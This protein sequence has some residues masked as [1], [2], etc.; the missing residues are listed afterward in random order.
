MSGKP[1]R[2]WTDLDLDRN[3]KATGYFRVPYSNDM[4]GYGSIPLPLCVVGNGDGPRV[5]LM[6]GNH[7]DEYE[8][9]VMLVKLLRALAPEN[10]QGR[11]IILPAAN[12]PAAYAGR[13]VSPIDG[14]NLNRLFPGDADG[15]PTAMIAHFIESTLLPRVDYVFDFH[16]GGVSTEYLPLAHVVLPEHEG[17]RAKALEFLRVFAM[18]VSVVVTGLLGG[19]QRL[20]GACE[21]RGISHM[22]TELG[23]AGTVSL[24]ALRAAE[25]GLRRLLH[26]VGVL[27]EPPA[28]NVPPPTRRMVRQP[29]RD[30]LYAPVDGIFEPYV[31]LGETV[32]V[33]QPAGAIHA[34]RAPWLPAT[35]LVFAHEGVVLARRHPAG[36][37]IGDA[38]FVLGR[39]AGE[40]F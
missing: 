11:I 7:G 21:R 37:E 4:S 8:G 20:L 25:A 28:D 16:S 27:R 38:L 18:P 36:T 33:G 40:V 26:H 3:G 10:I 17:R 19:D 35:E 32:R 30:F 14:G 9:Q 5:L 39:D 1:S 12:A 15:G 2:V 13:R 24:T 34:Q 31:A 6:A 29:M 23:G 22:S